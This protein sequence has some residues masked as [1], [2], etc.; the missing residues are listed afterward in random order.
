MTPHLWHP[1][2][3]I[4]V[5]ERAKNLVSPSFTHT[6]PPSFGTSGNLLGIFID[7]FS[8]G[9]MGSPSTRWSQEIPAWPALRRRFTG[10]TANFDSI[11]IQPRSHVKTIVKTM[12]TYNRHWGKL[13]PAL[14][15]SGKWYEGFFL[16]GGNPT[17]S[18]HPGGQDCILGTWATT[19]TYTT[20]FLV[21]IK[22]KYLSPD[23]EISSNS[24]KR[25]FCNPGCSKRL[26]KVNVVKVKRNNYC[27]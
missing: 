21:N 27:I 1:N 6:S 12:Y 16:G 23:S 17:S 7:Q 4:P 24:R 18:T 5:W 11:K 22:I 19:N 20:S 15:N 2:K 25:S 3:F 13:P 8:M 26:P 10:K 9:T 14:C